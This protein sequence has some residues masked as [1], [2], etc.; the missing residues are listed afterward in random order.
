MM[1]DALVIVTEI[2]AGIFTLGVVV[3]A[4][5]GLSGLV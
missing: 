5:N 4:L 1:H 3:L 2:V